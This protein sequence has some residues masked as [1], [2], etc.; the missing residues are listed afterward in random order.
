MQIRSQLGISMGFS[1]NRRSI[2][3]RNRISGNGILLKCI[4]NGRFHRV[5]EWIPNIRPGRFAKWEREWAPG[6]QHTVD[7]LDIGYD[8]G[9]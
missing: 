9:S 2:R 3:S 8:E 7:I 6:N 4:K 5:N 1:A